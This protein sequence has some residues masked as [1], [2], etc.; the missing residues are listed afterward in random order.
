MVFK[1]PYGFLIKHFKL[2][3]LI[4][5]GLFIW[6]TMKVSDVLDYYNRFI[7]GTVGKLE[8]IEHVTNYYIIG[9]VSSIVI[10]II[11]YALLRYK[12]KPRKLYLVLIGFVLIEAFIINLV[13]GGLE[14]IYISVLEMKTLRLYR[15]ILRILVVF[16]YVSIGFVL[17]RGLG[18]DI[19]KFNF[20]SDLQEL[21][22]DVSDEEEVE[23]TLGNTN[24][25]QRKINR[26]L[27]EFKYYYLENKTFIVIILVIL[28]A[29]GLGAS[30]VNKEVINKVYQQGESVSTD[31]FNFLVLDTFVTSKSHDNKIIAGEDDSFV[32]VKMNLSSN[33]GKK[34]L[35]TA[36][37]ILEVNYNSYA[38]NSYYG[39]RFI[40]LGTAYR[41]QKLSNVKTYLFIYKVSK[42]DINDKMKL[43]YA[44]DK[45]INLNPIMLDEASDEKS[46]KIG[47]M[48]DLSNS[49][50]GK[51]NF[52]I[53][54]CEVKMS[55]DYSY[56]YEID[57]RNFVGKY[58]INSAKGAVMRLKIS[59]SYIN[60]LN[61]YSFLDTYAIL[62]YKLNDVEYEVKSFDNKTP[63]DYKEGIY[64]SVDKNLLEAQEIW[65]DII[66]RNKRYIYKVK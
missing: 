8:A 51:G 37:M 53:D 24:V 59:S 58:A 66:I 7:A 41:E 56:N 65:F 35:N 46:Y 19:K 36:N 31:E 21:G 34:A 54:E 61:N 63:G 1:K 40:D 6:L 28:L 2:I 32:V 44:N 48:V 9:V 49:I 13:Y 45:T 42:D 20:A 55:F 5:T 15:D 12:Q 3:H 50:F 25:L 64:L 26:N 4:L 62:K 39:D 38:I 16:Q 18:F 14:D 17:V 57:G 11:V 43:V 10:C 52:K 22:M 30:F 23:L 60:N 27:R 29:L 47:E 33:V